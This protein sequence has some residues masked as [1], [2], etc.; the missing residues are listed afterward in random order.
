MEVSEL[1]ENPDGSFDLGTDILVDAAGAVK[2]CEPAIGFEDPVHA[3]YVDLA[4]QEATKLA[5]TSL[6]TQAGVAT[7]YIT[8]MTVRF[9]V[10]RSN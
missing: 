9:E 8:N 1:P 10:G 7:D 6:A 3:E 4:C 2:L 5:A